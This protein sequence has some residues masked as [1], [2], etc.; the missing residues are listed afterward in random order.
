MSSTDNF[1]ITLIDS[2]CQKISKDNIRVALS[3]TGGDELFYGY[4]KY[5]NAYKFQK[6]TKYFNNFFIEKFLK[7]FPKHNILRLINSD[8][9]EL[10]SYLKNEKNYKFIKKKIN[11]D[12][13]ISKY[14]SNENLFEDM[15]DFDLNFTLP[16]NINFNQ[17]IASMKNSVEIRCPFL[18]KEIFD[19]IER[20]N[21]ELL[22]SNGPKTLS[23]LL[24]HKYFKLEILKQGFTFTNE[25]MKKFI[26]TNSTIIDKY[27][28]NN[29]FDYNFQL[30]FKQL[31][32]KCLLDKFQSH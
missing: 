4:T 15:R 25:I 17:D 19:Y 16:Q 18:N 12:Q 20:I 14:F 5:Y 11:L 28:L 1:S 6:R 27:K 30:G 22:F 10:I 3:G 23:K 13:K 21:P 7:F 31:Y 8:S 9:L 2:I 26:N 24:L 32:K 29:Y